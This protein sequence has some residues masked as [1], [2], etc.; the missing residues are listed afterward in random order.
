ML[1]RCFQATR[2]YFGVTTVL[3][4]VHQ[5]PRY[6]GAP[7][8]RRPSAPAFELGMRQVH[9]FGCSRIVRYT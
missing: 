4:W 3:S 7:A 1:A 2:R 6:G 9:D 5:V 8:A